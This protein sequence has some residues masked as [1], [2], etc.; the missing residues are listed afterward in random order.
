MPL[1]TDEKVVETSKAIVGTL[2]GIFGPHP[3]CRP[4]HAKGILLDGTFTPTAAA[5]SLSKAQHFNAPSTPVLARLSS[6]TG[7]PQLPDNDPNGNPR[8]LA[9][10]FRLAEAPRRVHTDI[11]AHAADGFPGRTGEDA[12]AFFTA[13]KEGTIGEYL[14]GH[15]E[16]LAFVQLP[17]PF[18]ESFATEKFFAVNAFKLVDKDGKGTF[19]RYRIIP[20]AGVSHLTDEAAAARPGTYLFDALPQLLAAGP[21]EYKLTAQVA[22]DGDV[23]DDNTSHWPETRQ[24]VELGTIS[25]TQIAP[26]D[27]EAQQKSVIFDPIPRVEGVEPS[28]DPL[29]QA[30]AGIYLIS[31]RERRAA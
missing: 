6:S 5:A 25:L 30:R 17:K 21:I 12:L 18:P 10:R 14:G 1:P 16:A 29:L 22:E 13:L 7:I 28:D 3:G 8:G 27:N 15:P 26:G 2:K 24:I 9:V 20:S 4:A 23:T 11:I 19:V 31:G